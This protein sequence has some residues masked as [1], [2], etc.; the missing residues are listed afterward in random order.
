MSEV[1]RNIGRGVQVAICNSH[2]CRLLGL[3]ISQDFTEPEMLSLYCVFWLNIEIWNLTFEVQTESELWWNSCETQKVYVIQIFNSI[4]PMFSLFSI[5]WT[6]G[7]FYA[8]HHFE[9]GHVVYI[10]IRQF[11]FKLAK[12][13]VEW[14]DWQLRSLEKYGE[15]VY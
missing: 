14:M 8:S 12:H 10:W 7:T 3:D 4:F 2:P 5:L 1:L 11:P 13:C 15:W 6:T 9:I